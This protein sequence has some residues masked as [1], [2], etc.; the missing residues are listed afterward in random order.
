[1][2]NI[3]GRNIPSVARL[4]IYPFSKKDLTAGQLFRM[5]RTRKIGYHGSVR[6][7]RGTKTAK[8][9]NADPIV[10]ECLKLIR[11][12]SGYERDEF[13]E[14]LGVQH[15]TYRNYEG[16]IYPL[17]LKVVKTIREKLGYDLA[18]PDLTSDAI[19]TKI[20]EQRHDV[21]AAPDLAATEQVAKGVSCPQ[22]IRTCL[23]A[24]RQE[25]IG[26]Q[27]KRKHDIRDAVFVGAA[28]LFAF[29]LVV[30]RTEPQNIRLESIYTLMLSVSFLVAASIVPFQAIHMIQAA[31]RSRR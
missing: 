23:Q 8:S 15:K 3:F 27:S 18:D 31:Y 24:F 6:V 29:C 13:A 12:D 1:M 14:L 22:R 11:E 5:M 25:L 26:V 28:A 30:L 16:C 21:A 7:A 10:A 19:I 2:L 20:A 17:P 4:L 9:K